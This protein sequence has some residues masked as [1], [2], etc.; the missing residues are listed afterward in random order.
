MPVNAAF[1]IVRRGKTGLQSFAKTMYKLSWESRCLV[2]E[3]GTRFALT[4]KHTVEGP[5]HL[6]I[7]VLEFRLQVTTCFKFY[8]FGERF[9]CFRIYMSVFT[10]FCLNA[11]CSTCLTSQLTPAPYSCVVLSYDTATAVFPILSSPKGFCEHS[12]FTP[13]A[14]VIICFSGSSH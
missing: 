10:C 4:S 8:F 13:N 14:N 5:G 9:P 1:T 3:L 7:L 2:V 11:L 12:C 6:H